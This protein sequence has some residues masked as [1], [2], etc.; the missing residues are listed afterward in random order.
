MF[1]T[2]SARTHTLLILT[3][4][5]SSIREALLSWK[6]CLLKSSQNRT[7][8]VMAFNKQD[9]PFPKMIQN[10]TCK[11]LWHICLASLEWKSQSLPIKDPHLRKCFLSD[12][13]A[14]CK[15]LV[16]KMKVITSTRLATFLPLCTL[17]FQGKYMTLK[18]NRKS[19]KFRKRNLLSKKLE[20]T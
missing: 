6:S 2:S 11:M 3:I 10:S 19:P 4:C 16:L 20:I 17:N 5:K 8:S 7:R 9:S 15:D 18:A 1:L 14:T 13:M 12:K